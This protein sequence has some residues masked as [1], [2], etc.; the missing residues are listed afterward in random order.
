ML[1]SCSILLDKLDFLRRKEPK[2]DL[3]GVESRFDLIAL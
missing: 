2:G 3:E 1:P